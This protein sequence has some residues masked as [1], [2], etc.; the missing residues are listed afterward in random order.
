M[1]GFNTAHH[2]DFQ[3]EKHRLGKT[4]AFSLNKAKAMAVVFDI[5][6]SGGSVRMRKGGEEKKIYVQNT[7]KSAEDH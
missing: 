6:P 2:P 5:G 1:T 4:K 3:F 7:I